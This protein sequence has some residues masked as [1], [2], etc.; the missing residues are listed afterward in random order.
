MAANF[1]TLV[2]KESREA[3]ARRLENTILRPGSSRRIVVSDEFSGCLP[4]VREISSRTL[5]TLLY[6]RSFHKCTLSMQMVLHIFLSLAQYFLSFLLVQI[7][8]PDNYFYQL[9]TSALLN[10][11]YFASGCFNIFLNLFFNKRTTGD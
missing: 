3:E 2:L 6:L 7:R 8:T 5:S 9:T 10:A 1:C 11:S 4:K